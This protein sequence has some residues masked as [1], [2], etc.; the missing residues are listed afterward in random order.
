MNAFASV[1]V[2]GL[3][4]F[5]CSASAQEEATVRERPLAAVEQ[6][7][8]PAVLA[9]LRQ[10][11]PLEYPS[12]RSVVVL[13][14]G[15]PVL[16]LY[17][18]GL[19]SATL[20]DA[21]FA[22]ASFVS[23]LVGIAIQQGRIKSV[24]QTISELLP[25]ALEGGVDSRV[26]SMTLEHILTL[27][28]GFDPSVKQVGKWAFPVAFA[29]R[30]PLV[31]DP[32]AV[33][34][35][36]PGTAHLA[37]RVLVSATKESLS[38]FAKKHL[39]GPLEIE[40]FLWRTDGPGGNELGYSGLQ[41]TARDMAKLGQLFL[42]GGVWNGKALLPSAYVEAATRKQNSGG[43]P[44]GWSYGYLWWASPE[45]P[46]VFEAAGDDGQRIYVDRVELGGGSGFGP[47]SRARQCS[48]RCRR[49]ARKVGASL[50]QKVTERV[51]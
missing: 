31:S 32:G 18:D 12:I 21:R 48:H 46:T 19:N 24:K 30:L 2:V 1:L 40:R 11:L 13:R 20:H 17:R 33:F 43:P 28:A 10:R 15:K 3:T 36:N 23:A 22:T 5:L 27:T 25:E 45:N 44:L 42:Q 29:L 47:S 7:L 41:L 9:E 4:L 38:V 14:H 51:W 35:F 26:R 39:F 37:A 34:S 50:N 6:G 16:E 8:D 49:G